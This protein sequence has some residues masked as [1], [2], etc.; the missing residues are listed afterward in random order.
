MYHLSN[1]A[2]CFE[3]CHYFWLLGAFPEPNSPN[4]GVLNGTSFL[5]RWKGE[6]I[7]TT[8]VAD[9]IGML[10]FIEE[11]NV[12]GVAVPGMNIFQVLEEFSERMCQ[13]FFSLQSSQ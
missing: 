9:I 11:S 1:N 13:L 12:Y 3:N 6:N 5:F 2:F 8:E 4:I 7:A 10:D